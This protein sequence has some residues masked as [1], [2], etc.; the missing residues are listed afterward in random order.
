MILTNSNIVENRSSFRKLRILII[1]CFFALLL[2][3]THAFQIEN[4]VPKPLVEPLPINAFI[5]YPSAF[6]EYE[7]R[8]ERSDG[9]V[10]VN[11]IGSAQHE[12]FDQLFES[13]FTSA[14][15]ISDLN[16]ETLD[17][18]ST[19]L[20]ITLAVDDY[21]ISKPRDS[22]LDFYE[23]TIRYGLSLYNAQGELIAAWSVNGYGRDRRRKFLPFAAAAEATEEAMRDA[24]TLIA[25]NLGATSEI[26]SII[27][28]NSK[29]KRRVV[30]DGM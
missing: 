22:G 25:V 12:L 26:K 11:Q 14:E 24:A 6:L 18:L 20:I 10:L 16:I 13:L 8:E 17:T 9:S 3:C 21:A 7:Y 5:Y 15:T 4:T 27:R 1:A 23:V 30:Q 2:G 28:E 19:D 29:P